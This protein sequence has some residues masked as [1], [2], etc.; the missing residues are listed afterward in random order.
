MS[1]TSIAVAATL[2]FVSPQP[3]I[4]ELAVS[5][6]D[7]NTLVTAVTAA[8]L[9]GTLSGQG[10]FT[11]FAPADSAFA[12]V[13]PQVL[14]SVLTEPGTPTLKR[15]L[16]H[17]V[18]S[19]NLMAS[20]LIGR[21]SVTTLAGTELPVSYVQGRVL[22]GDAAVNAADL[23]A[24]NGVVHVIDRVLMPPPAQNPL[25][26]LLLVTIERGVP[27]YNDGNTGACAT[28]Y[29]TALEAI[30][31]SGGFGL[32]ETD[33]SQ[34]KTE[35]ASASA[36]ETDSDKA[37]AYRRIIDRLAISADT[38]SMTTPKKNV[39]TENAL[40]GFD[41]KNESRNWDIV[42]DGVMGGR[43]TGEVNIDNGSMVF[44]GKTSLENNGGFSSI[45]RNL[46]EGS[47]RGADAI[48]MR[49]RGDGRTWIIGTRKS[50]VR[51]ADSY[52][53]RF[54]TEKDTW[55]S[56]VIPINEMER[57]FFGERMA[58]RISPD[59]V[60]AIEFYMY[61]KKAGPFRLEVDQIDA[62]KLESAS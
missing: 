31:L 32:S 47:M 45:R 25:Y 56:V 7:L 39:S 13:D 14:Q 27:L 20:D 18:V 48:K 54:P 24:S 60:R 61:D 19:G 37:W 50:S 41:N 11:V 23:R 1:M 33:R 57:H 6:D 2:A 5:S 62:I 26:E 53:K 10:P 40:L 9:A 46:K 59:D 8:D 52:W 16:T 3:N 36:S 58:G 17:H 34:L 43:S 4:V 12:Q 28:V 22:I 29:V 15:I 30:Y 42:L 35:I 49:V 21:D 38:S 55:T 51:G 44:T